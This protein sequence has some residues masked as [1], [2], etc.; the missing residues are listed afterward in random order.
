M[1]LDEKFM[2]TPLRLLDVGSNA[3]ERHVTGKRRKNQPCQFRQH[4]DAAAAYKAFNLGGQ[5]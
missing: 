3:S 5:I 2:V 1:L 4:G